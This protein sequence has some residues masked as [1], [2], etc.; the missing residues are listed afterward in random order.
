M[1]A[2][3]V[4]VGWDS[5]LFA[6]GALA[7][8]GSLRIVLL[9]VLLS[10]AAIPGDTVNGWVGKFLGPR[11]I[12]GR[13]PRFP[14][15]EYLD[16]THAFFEKDGG[17]TI[18]IARYKPIVRTFVPFVAGVG[19]MTYVTFLAYNAIGGVVW[20]AICGLGGSFFGGLAVAKENFLLVVMATIECLRPC[21]IWCT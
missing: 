17:K 3:D 9:L 7:G 10:A 18:I 4:D 6:A 13:N 1:H 20:V 15:K 21:R 2:A 8:R 16:R 12:R 5:L 19:A 11:M 14:R